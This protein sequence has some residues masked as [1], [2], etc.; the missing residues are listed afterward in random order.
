MLSSWCRGPRLSRPL[1]GERSRSQL[2]DIQPLICCC[3]RVIPALLPVARSERAA[4]RVSAFVWLDPLDLR[5]VVD[6]LGQGAREVATLVR[7]QVLCRTLVESL[8]LALQLLPNGATLVCEVKANQAGVTFV[9]PAFQQPRGL[10]PS[11]H[12]DHCRG[13]DTEPLGDLPGRQAVLV[14]E[15][16]EDEVLTHAHAVPAKGGVCRS[17]HQL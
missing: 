6:H 11:R 4:G 10:H 16:L 12:L 15:L 14:P 2:L 1:P 5:E 17:A 8:P 9:A 13:A 3:L 7:G